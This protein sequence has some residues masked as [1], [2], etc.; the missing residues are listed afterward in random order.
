MNINQ[1]LKLSEYFNKLANYKKEVSQGDGWKITTN[2]GYIDYRYNPDD[3]G[4]N[5]IWWIESNE[6]GGGT[7]LVDLMMNESPAEAIAWGVTSK[8]GEEFMK[9]YHA[10]HPDI[11]CITGPFEGQ[12]D[13]YERQYEDDQEDND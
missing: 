13:P 1:I 10:K 2:Y 9:R 11:M 5:E 6:P 8:Q 3:G 12:F 4:I 7:K